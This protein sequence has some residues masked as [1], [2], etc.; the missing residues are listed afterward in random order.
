MKMVKLRHE[1]TLNQGNFHNCNDLVSDEISSPL[2]IEHDF[3]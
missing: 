2:G 1:A 3:K